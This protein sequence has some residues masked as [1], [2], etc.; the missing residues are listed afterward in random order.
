[1]TSQSNAKDRYGYPLST[2]SNQAAEHYIVGVD[3]LL[4]QNFGAEQRLED[5]IEADEG[6]A[7]AH[8][9]L[10]FLKM[11]RGLVSQARESAQRAR[12]LSP[13]TSLRE[14]QQVEAVALWV[15]GKGLQSLTMIRE[16]LLEFPRDALL[17]RLAQRLYMLGCS[18]S[19][20]P[21]FPQELMALLRSVEGHYGDDWSFLGQY[22][23]AHHEKLDGTGY[24]LGLVDDEIP[25]GAKLMTI[26]DI[27]DALTAGDRPYKSGM[28]PRRA[29][30][31]LREEASKG[32]LDT[33]AVELFAAKRI[34]ST[35]LY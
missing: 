3:L 32:R 30:F 35:A 2:G 34:W 6:F 7:V 23:F 11:T 8:G 20:V 21:N 19:G 9:A 10:A 31:I 18:G 5:A 22:A 1:M 12:D 4:S 14:R 27:F 17:L 33:D 15:E 28:G 25:F 13:G 16:H 29:L 26:S 24:P